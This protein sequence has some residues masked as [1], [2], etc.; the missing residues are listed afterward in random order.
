[1]IGRHSIIDVVAKLKETR[2]MGIDWTPLDQEFLRPY[3]CDSRI[4]VTFDQP[5]VS[6]ERVS[7]HQFQIKSNHINFTQS[8]FGMCAGEVITVDLPGDGRPPIYINE[9]Y[10]VD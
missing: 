4:K 7:E 6:F 1:M 5:Y 8:A 2:S 9:I 10:F 3:G